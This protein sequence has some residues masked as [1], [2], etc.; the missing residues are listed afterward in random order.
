MNLNILICTLDEGIKKANKILHPLRSDVKYIVSH[1]YRDEKHKVIPKE[2]QREDI[3]VS[4]IPGV[5]LSRNRN[6]ALRLA[7][8]DIALIA[9]DDVRYLPEAFDLIR[10]VFEKNTDVDVAL[11]KIKTPEGEPEYKKYPE[12]EYCLNETRKHY[13]SSI[14]IAFKIKAIKEANIVFDSKYGLGNNSFNRGEEE[15][16]LID[17]FKAKLNVK[18]FPNY[19][20]LHQPMSSAKSNT[21]FNKSTV[22]IQGAIDARKTGTVAVFK[23]GVL[24][25]FFLPQLIRNKVNPFKYLYYRLIGVFYELFY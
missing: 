12:G 25:L 6:N 18:Y 4:Q 13:I 16:L 10:E 17:C 20:V 24:M 7:D 11:F 5:G 1:Q 14:E 15:I 3:I 22:S 23:S 8:G 9:D 21:L 2:L 19:T